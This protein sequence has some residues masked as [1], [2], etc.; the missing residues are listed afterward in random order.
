MQSG[1]IF[2]AIPLTIDVE[3][4]EAIAFTARVVNQG[5]GVAG[6]SAVGWYSSS[7]PTGQRSFVA[8]SPIESLSGSGTTQVTL[9]L[10][11]G[12]PG[13][14]YMF[15]SADRFLHR[16]EQRQCRDWDNQE[17]CQVVYEL[18]YQ[19]QRLRLASKNMS[20]ISPNGGLRTDSM[21]ITVPIDSQVGT[22]YHVG[23]FAD[24]GD[25]VQPET[26]TSNNGL[27]TP[28]LVTSPSVAYSPSSFRFD[29]TEG[30]PDPPSK[31]LGVK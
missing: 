16:A 15:A 20:S 7:T 19:P 2:S 14:V 26:N 4:G 9:N 11:A 27:G 30:G 31:T 23:I 13:T 28:V 12:V 6:S 18:N 1:N 29:A 3:E 17:L 21:Q 25:V 8:S 24:S 5:T 22:T 10:A